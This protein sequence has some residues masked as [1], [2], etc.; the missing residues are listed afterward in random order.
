MKKT[1]SQFKV[2]KFVKFIY[3]FII[4]YFLLKMKLTESLVLPFIVIIIGAIAMVPYSYRI[5]F[6]SVE[7][8]IKL[9]SDNTSKKT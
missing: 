8:E 7:N 6:E 2:L 5:K 4:F 1:G 3:L 9:I